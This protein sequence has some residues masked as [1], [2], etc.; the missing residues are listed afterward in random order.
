[1]EAGQEEEEE[2]GEREENRYF[3]S[4]PSHWEKTLYLFCLMTKTLEGR[5]FAGKLCLW[6]AFCQ[7]FLPQKP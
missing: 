7:F 6:E 1:M 3:P 2:E 4:L 5:L